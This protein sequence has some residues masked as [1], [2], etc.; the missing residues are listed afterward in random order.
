M[1]KTYMIPAL[2][3]VKIQ[4]TQILAGSEIGKGGDYTGG[5]VQARRGRFSEWDEDF[6]DE[7]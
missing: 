6:Y 3:V 2:K 1:K 5:G 4:P 7:E